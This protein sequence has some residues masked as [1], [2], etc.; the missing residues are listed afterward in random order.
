MMIIIIILIIMIIIISV[1]FPLLARFTLLLL[2]LISIRVFYH[3]YSQF[4][5]ERGGHLFNSSLPVPPTS[6]TP[7]DYCRELT[8]AHS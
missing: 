7:G 8:S 3:E 4:T 1:L 5:G 2:L 6:Q